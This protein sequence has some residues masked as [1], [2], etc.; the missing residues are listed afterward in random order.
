MDKESQAPAY[1]K[2]EKLKKYLESQERVAVAFSG[3][4]DSAFL[5]KTAQEACPGQV[6]A[7]TVR[8]V[9][10]PAREL[11]EA[12]AFCSRYG[13]LQEVCSVDV[14]Q[15]EGFCANPQNRCYL[16]KR[17][18][19][20]QILDIAAKHQITC[21]LEGS[22]LDDDGDFRPGRQAVLEA[23]IRSPLR[24]A[25]M[26]KADIRELARQQGLPVW[27]KPSFACLATRF[28][29][30]EQITAQKLFMVEQA[31]QFLLDAGFRQ[32]RV[33]MHGRMARIEL[34]PEDFDRIMQPEVRRQVTAAFRTYGFLYTALD[35]SGY[36]TG[37]MNQLQA[38]SA[39]AL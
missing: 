8:A 38:D 18:L 7:V 15:A 1:K 26:T 9:S 3:G 23:G 21:V 16:C 6:L 34:L 11:E 29:Y 27:D 36:K 37:N 13:I 10:F 2:L 5:L 31:E 17:V 25:G 22:N 35:L 24:D 19:L 39:A 4:T 30:G 28:P 20:A 14:L 33:R 12:E 32:V